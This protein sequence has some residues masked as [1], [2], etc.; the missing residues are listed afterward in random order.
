MDSIEKLIN[1]FSQFPTVGRRTAGRFV[2]Y[3][4]RQPKE[5]VTELTNAIE[6][7]RNSVKLCTFCF[8]P[9][10]RTDSL[11]DIC[12]NPLRNKLLCI[13]E[14]EQDLLSIE[15]TKKY[16]GL[17]F[18]LGGMIDTKNIKTA[19]LKERLTKPDSFGIKSAS[20][21]EIIIALNPTVEGIATSRA[22]E[23]SLKEFLPAGV[24]IS[25]LAK[26]LPMGG[27][28]EY[29]DDETLENAL[30]GRK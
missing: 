11:C 7:L 27:E 23:Q 19:E 6:E 14:K 26:G 12:A 18:I 15:K 22:V 25:H 20:F 16:N 10:E 13:V 21:S 3:L 4:L 30:E 24:K 5:T 1:L 9:H 8:N 28:L 29:A 17:Y 2:F